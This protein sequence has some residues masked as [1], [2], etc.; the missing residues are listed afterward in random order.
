M[1]ETRNNQVPEPIADAVSAMLAPYNLDFSVFS[2]PR[3]STPSKKYLSVAD[4]EEYTSVSRWTL[5]RA[6]KDSKL[7]VIKLSKA[8]SGKVLFERETLD[9]WLQSLKGV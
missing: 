5:H 2:N 1:H 3:P 8:K 4:A 7:Q 9:A 6:V